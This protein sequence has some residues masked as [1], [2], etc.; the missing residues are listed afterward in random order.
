[1]KTDKAEEVGKM[2]QEAKE[3]VSIFDEIASKLN[4]RTIALYREN[5]EKAVD[6]TLRR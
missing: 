5:L 3:F 2:L 4:E 1:M 6:R